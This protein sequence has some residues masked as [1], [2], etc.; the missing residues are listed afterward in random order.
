MSSDRRQ[1]EREP[2]SDD[3]LRTYL[4]EIS[5]TPLLTK[6][7]EVELGRRARRGDKEAMEQL[8]RSNLRFVVSLAK[9]YANSG[10]PLL[11]LINEG[12]IGLIEAAK[13]FDPEKANRFIT[14]AKWWIQQAIR[15]ALAAQASVVRLP[16]KQ[17]LRLQTIKNAYEELRNKL[18][19]PPQPSEVARH[20][21]LTEAEV[22]VLLRASA[23][24]VSI[25]SSS[26]QGR[27]VL[28]SDLDDEETYGESEIERA[29]ILQSYTDVLQEL[30]EKLSNQERKVLT[31]RFGLVDD[32]KRSL[33]SIGQEM[34][35]SRERVRQIESMALRKIR[36]YAKEKRLSIIL[37]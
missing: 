9:K 14:Y 12:N 13:K 8:V 7:Q 37:N 18:D 6:K 22:E 16:T 27:D 10:V 4:R 15:S 3:I 32:E 21:G 36:Q 29:L 1:E 31:L 11:D 25:E 35:L 24:A 33:E 28:Q 26:E 2:A 17:R 34:N 20:I 30:I 23:D 5:E 19:R